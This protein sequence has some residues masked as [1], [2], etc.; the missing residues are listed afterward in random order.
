MKEKLEKLFTMLGDML[1]ERRAGAGGKMLLS[2]CLVIF[3]VGSFPAVEYFKGIVDTENLEAAFSRDGSSY[4]R[5]SVFF[6]RKSEMDRSGIMQ[7]RNKLTEQLSNSPSLELEEKKNIFWDAY[8]GTEQIEVSYQNHFQQANALFVGGHY[9]EFHNMSFLSGGKFSEEDLVRDK[10]V[11]SEELSFALFGSG[12]SVGKTIWIQEKGILICGVVKEKKDWV[13]KLADTDTKKIYLPYEQAEQ[14]GL[15]LPLTSYEILL[16]EPL[17]GFARKTVE[18]VLSVNSYEREA[19][20]QEKEISILE[21]TTRFSLMKLL[22]TGWK[23]HERTMKKVPI[24]FPDWENK[25][26]I[27]ENQL[28]VL[29]MIRILI[30]IWLVWNLF[31]C[32]WRKQKEKK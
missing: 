20:M 11:I 19:S 28:L 25:R 32:L 13:S 23:F 17:E 26:I 8:E 30:L 7:L 15:Q 12:N 27:V 10:A 1:K 16:P 24:A 9:F 31:F 3:F 14:L 22:Q 6:S 21:E 29:Y 5:I 4:K 18:D 2:I